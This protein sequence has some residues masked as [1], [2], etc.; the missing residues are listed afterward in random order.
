SRRLPVVVV[1]H[2]SELLL[3]SDGAHLREGIR[4]LDEFVLDALVVAL[5]TIVIDKDREGGPEV[6]FTQED[7]PAQTL[8][9]DRANKSFRIGIALRNAR[10]T[11][12]DFDAGRFENLSKALA[13]FGIAVNDQVRFAQRE[14]VRCVDELTS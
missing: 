1:Q 10:R 12:N 7:Q 6:C 13:V 2:P 3:T 8:L 4:W 5:V 11:E 9:L 14:T